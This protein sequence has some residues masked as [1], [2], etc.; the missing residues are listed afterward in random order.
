M[1]DMK[2]EKDQEDGDQDGPGSG[3]DSEPTEQ[4]SET[5]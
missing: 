5:I 2:D 3:D 4:I 1:E